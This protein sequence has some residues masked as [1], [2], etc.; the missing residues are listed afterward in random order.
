MARRNWGTF[1]FWGEWLFPKW[2]ISFKLTIRFSYRWEKC[3]IPYSIAQIY[4]VTNITAK[5]ILF[6]G[7]TP[8]TFKEKYS[9]FVTSWELNKFL[10]QL[11]AVFQD[12]R[13]DHV[14]F[15]FLLER[16][17]SWWLDI[18]LSVVVL[19]L[20]MFISWM[21]TFMRLFSSLYQS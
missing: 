2:C 17:K 19:C 14:P 4:V 10:K 6:L 1:Q 5:T 9:L 11:E 13:S 16:N 3:A 7:S 21:W 18:M 8:H 12:Q 15:F 20:G